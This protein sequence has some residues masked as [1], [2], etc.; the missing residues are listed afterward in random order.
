MRLRLAAIT[1]GG[2]RWM[3]MFFRI[4]LARCFFFSASVTLRCL[5]V[6]VACEIGVSNYGDGDKRT[7]GTGPGFVDVRSFGREEVPD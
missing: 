5:H 3:S 2:V 1:F 7:L 4:M 6:S